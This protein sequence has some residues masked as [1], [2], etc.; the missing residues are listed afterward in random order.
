MIHCPE[1]EAVSV[2][3]LASS[4]GLWP[5]LRGTVHSVAVVANKFKCCGAR[6]KERT[7]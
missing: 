3:S 6:E 4:D 2:V 5:F 7:R 1:L